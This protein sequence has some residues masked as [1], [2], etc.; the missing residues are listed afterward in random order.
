VDVIE[1]DLFLR[2]ELVQ[3]EAEG[4]DV[5]RQVRRGFLEHHEHARLGKLGGAAH[6]EFHGQHGLAATRAAA[7]ERGPSG[8]EP[9]AGD[10]IEPGDAGGSFGRTVRMTG[11]EG[12]LVAID[13][14]PGVREDGKRLSPD[15]PDSRWRK[16]T[17]R[18]RQH[19]LGQGRAREGPSGQDRPDGGDEQFGAGLLHQVATRS[20]LK[21]PYAIDPLHR[22][23]RPRARG[24]QESGTSFPRSVQIHCDPAVTD[25]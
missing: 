5:G 23:S 10:F 11:T 17:R 22:A 19:S 8:G 9:S 16:S 12:L 2:D 1:H 24:S 7:D 21:H 20:G 15:G 25:P 6:E 4:T 14:K 3:I 13:S 18:S